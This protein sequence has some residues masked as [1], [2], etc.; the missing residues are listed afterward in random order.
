MTLIQN[1]YRLHGAGQF[2][3]GFLYLTYSTD[4]EMDHLQY[5]FAPLTQAATVPEPATLALLAVGIAGI[6]FARRRFRKG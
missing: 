2:M 3:T 4:W 5:G 6:G 1:H